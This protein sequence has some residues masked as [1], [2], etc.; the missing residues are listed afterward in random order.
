VRKNFDTF[1]RAMGMFTP[2]GPD[3]A[4]PRAIEGPAA[5]EAKPAAKSGVKPGENEI[6][7]L[8]AELQAVQQRLEKLSRG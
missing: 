7:T 1:E 2:F 5:D 4:N 3:A 6:D 8:K